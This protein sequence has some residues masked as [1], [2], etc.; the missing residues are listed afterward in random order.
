[1][2][3][4]TKMN[5]LN[6]ISL[7]DYQNIVRQVRELTG[8]DLAEFATASLRH[9]LSRC[10]QIHNFRF[11]DTL[12]ARIREDPVFA[13]TFFSDLM[14]ESTEYFRDPG[15]WLFLREN[16][17]PEILRQ[18]GTMK[19]WVPSCVSGDE[20][21]S[22]IILL[23]EMEV[24]NNVRIQATC[25]SKRNLEHILTG[26][27]RRDKILSGT[28]NY[29]LA[30]GQT[31]LTD[32]FTSKGI[33]Y[34]KTLPLDS[35]LEFNISFLPA[36]KKHSVLFDMILFRNQMLYYGKH[37][38][39]YTLSLLYQNLHQ[40]G[41]LVVGNKEQIDLSYFAENYLIVNEEEKIYR[42]K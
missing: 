28:E 12:I 16:I 32:Y 19:I 30:G 7:V 6:E 10:I 17:I 4:N 27:T 25:P 9:R 38:Q 39:N 18:K 14:V 42:K 24:L 33:L 26:I 2:E 23:H 20:L 13:D 36:D 1:M 8:V 31:Q 37:L 5:T 35:F 34:Y 41:I 15:M 22:L 21:Y 3:R 40:G 29:L 11:A